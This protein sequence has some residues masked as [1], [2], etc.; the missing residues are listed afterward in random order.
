MLE[1]LRNASKGWLAVVLILMLVGSFGMWGVEDMLNLSE[2][3]KIARVGDDNISPERFQQ[4]FARF[5]SQMSKATNSEMT[6]QQA[7]ALGLDRVALDRFTKK[8]ALLKLAK[9]MGMTISPSQIVDALRPIQGMVDKQGKLVPGA[10]SQIARANDISESQFIELIT[11]DLLR[12]QLLRSVASGVGLPRGL[13]SALN[14]FRL[15]RRV[16]EYVVIDPSRAGQM[17]DPNSTALKKYYDD[18]AA[19]RYSIPETREVAFLMVKPED[20]AANISVPEADIVK[21]YA[22]NKKRYDV[23]EKRVLEQI[24]FK[25]EEKA[26]AARAKLDAGEKFEAVAKAEGFSAEDI[27]YGEV[28][29]GDQSVPAVA[30]ELP[31]AQAS[32]AVKNSFGNWVIVRTVSTTPGTTKTLADVH[33]EIRKAIADNKAKDQVFE[34]TNQIEDTLGAGATLEEASKKLGLQLHKLT[35]T[36]AGV[37][38]DGKALDGLPGGDFVQQVFAADSGADPELLQ[39]PEG[40]YY[41]FRIDKV[42]KSAKK[43]L[44]TITDQVLSDWRK[45]ETAK[46]LQTMADN[47]LKRAKSGEN[48]TSVASSLGLSLV[49][50]DPIP[51]YGKTVTFGEAAV[52]AASDAKKGEFFAGP[53]AF[54]EGVVVGRVV[55]IVFQPEPADSPARSAYLQRLGQ[56]FVSDFVEQFE[57]GARTKVGTK[58]DEARFQSFH[59]NE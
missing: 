42:N 23:P 56:S 26:R 38:P 39:T 3:P 43:P 47:V 10:I 8:L 41:E 53:V 4:E 48:F 16:A 54:G 28:S 30:F 21:I 19:L 50:S 31:I 5:L 37:D 17:P 29:K 13:E 12:E 44:D 24:R 6:S 58:V 25:T 14:H 46:K 55:D 33:E 22:A 1:T 2:Q 36:S 11:G 27:K 52:S 18:N 59:N 15:E 32:A 35:L 20:V 51:R 7:K 45:E 57:N 9:D 34:L 49:T 40:V